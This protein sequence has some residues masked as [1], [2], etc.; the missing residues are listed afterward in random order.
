MNTENKGV[1]FYVGLF[2]V[3]AIVILGAMFV[4]FGGVSTGFQGH[5]RVTVEFP[6]A[7]GIIKDAKVLLAGAA[8]GY[9]EEQPYLLVRDGFG[10]GVKL[11]IRDD[12]K[13]PRDSQFVIDQSGL[14]GDTYVDVLPPAVIDPNNLIG[15]GEMIKG[16]TKPGLDVLQQK[17]ALVLTQLSGEIDSLQQLTENLNKNILSAANTKN[18]SETL[19][20]LRV[21]SLN[22]NTSTAKLDGILEKGDAAVASAKKTFETADK[23]AEDLRDAMVDFKKTAATAGKTLDSAKSFVDT[24]T[25]VLKKAEQGEGAL[26]MLLT[27]KEAAANIKAFTENLRRSGPVFYKDRAVA[28]GPQPQ[29]PQ[30]P[31]K[32]KSSPVGRDGT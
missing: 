31:T 17:G 23:A 29:Q 8:I 32:R 24:G 3:I 12:V 22:L 1:E 16:T 14:L 19:E 28:P 18:L 10:V 15:P 30:Q 7:S 5:Y 20:H 25:R 13:L 6:N 11:K 27:D 9:V 4:Q 26:G 2:L 21:T